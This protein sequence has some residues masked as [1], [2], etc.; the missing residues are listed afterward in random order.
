[1]KPY[2]IMAHIRAASG[3]DRKTV[4]IAC[5]DDG[6]VEVPCDD[7]EMD[8]PV[9]YGDVEK[10]VK[11]VAVAMESTPRALQQAADLGC[12][13]FIAHHETFGYPNDTFEANADSPVA[14]AK[15]AIL[16][17]SAMTVI[18]V[19][20]T[21]DLTPEIGVFDTWVRLL[22]YE[23]CKW[24]PCAPVPK[25]EPWIR[26]A[27]FMKKLHIPE[28]SLGELARHVAEVVAPYGQNGVMM[29]GDPELAVRT[30]G[31][32]DGGI[33]DVRSYIDSGCDAGI[34]TYMG[35][36]WWADSMGIGL[37]YVEHTVSELQG[38]K[39]LA[40]FLS[41]TLPDLDVHYIDN[42]C[43]FTVVSASNE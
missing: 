21:W 36:N 40:V 24:E 37:I 29:T 32:G 38:M 4:T 25:W 23:D 5:G 19:H 34:I 22:G 18:R 15:K 16:D 26:S 17:D 2:E 11:S 12:D 1:M 31:V 13:L 30:L 43:P 20:G 14:A 8:R 35:G 41:E 9:S 33:T 27:V 28:T 10:D 42:G 3:L 7:S 6:E 39:N